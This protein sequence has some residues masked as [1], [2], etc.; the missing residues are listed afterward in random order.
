MFNLF[1]ILK[2]NWWYTSVTNS[3]FL[4]KLIN[5]FANNVINKLTTL[6]A[7]RLILVFLQKCF[8][9]GVRRR[10]IIFQPTA[11]PSR[12]DE[13]IHLYSM[14]SFRS[15]FSNMDAGGELNE[16][17]MSSDLGYSWS[18]MKYWFSFMRSLLSRSASH[19]IVALFFFPLLRF[20]VGSG[21]ISNQ[22]VMVRGWPSC[23]KLFSPLL[24]VFSVFLPVN[25][26]SLSD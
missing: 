22:N 3:V 21:I 16:N 4:N 17:A 1:S 6:F 18:A 24:L 19:S 15:A 11:F 23:T 12:L 7:E 13:T 5:R 9:S 14:E 8:N 25:S 2:I 26:F 10:N 20:K